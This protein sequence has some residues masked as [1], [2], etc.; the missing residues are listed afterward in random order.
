MELPLGLKFRPNDQ[1][2]VLY[3]L[4][5]KVQ[6]NPIFEDSMNVIVDCDVFGDPSAWMKIF[7]ETHMDRLYFYTKLK[8]KNKHIERSTHS[9]TW[10]SQKDQELYDDS[11]TIH[12]GSKR[13]FSFVAKNGFNGTGR[14]TM[15]EYR[16]DGEFANTTNHVS[17]FFFFFLILY[18]YNPYCSVS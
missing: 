2:I 11:K 5:N 12:Y 13:S 6:G 8:K 18:I 3:Y 17:F 1:E 14:W 16:L 15:N 4:L 7:Q 10:R 9:A